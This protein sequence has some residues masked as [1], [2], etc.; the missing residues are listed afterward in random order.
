MPDQAAL[1]PKGSLERLLLVAAF[2][3]SG[4][5]TVGAM[6]CSVPCMGETFEARPA[7]AQTVRLCMFSSC[8]NKPAT[9]AIIGVFCC[10]P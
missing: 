5:Q 10:L 2:A 4:F 6:M 1:Q 8:A 7:M 9:C 3:V